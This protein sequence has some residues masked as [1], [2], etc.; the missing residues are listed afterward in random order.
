[1]RAR[2]TRRRLAMLVVASVLPI[3]ARA[4]GFTTGSQLMQA[5]S[6]PGV[7]A[8]RECIGY[9]AGA[10]DQV[11]ANPTLKGTLCPLPQGVELKDVKAALVKFGREHPDKVGQPA[12]RL[13]NDAIGTKYPCK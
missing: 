3:V 13:L 7:P 8:D 12:V 11:S 10:A 5:C 2:W 1:M 4:E 6:T 9:I